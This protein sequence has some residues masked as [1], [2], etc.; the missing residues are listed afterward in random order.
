[1]LGICLVD[2]EWATQCDGTR[3]VFETKQA[4]ES[5]IVPRTVLD[6][7][8]GVAD[9]ERRTH[10][11]QRS[12]RIGLPVRDPEPLIERPGPPGEDALTLILPDHTEHCLHR[13]CLDGAQ[14]PVVLDCAQ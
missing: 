7:L 11:L 12:G 14:R 1:M 9:L 3:A 10:L 8:D 2:A 13:F 6:V 5:L 4:C